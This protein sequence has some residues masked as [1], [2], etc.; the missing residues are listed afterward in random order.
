MP[1]HFLDAA[2]SGKTDWWRYGVGITLVMSGFIVMGTIALLVFSLPFVIT[3]ARQLSGDDINAKLTDFLLGNPSPVG[4]LANLLPH[5]CGLAT[6]ILVVSVIHQRSPL[7]LI[8]PDCQIRWGRVGWGF[9][10]WW[11]LM[12]GIDGINAAF[13]P[14]AFFLSL[15]QVNWAAWWSFVPVVFIFI[16]LQ[17]SAE[18]LFFRSYLIQGLGLLN[19]NPL[20]I[21]IVGG[22]MFALPHFFNPE[23]ERGA[24]WMGLTYFAMGVFGVLIT[25]RDNRL[26]LALGE[27]AAN[28]I[29]IALIS[30]SKDS[31]LKT[32]AILMHDDPDPQ[33][34]FW[35][36][37]AVMTLAY[38]LFFVWPKRQPTIKIKKEVGE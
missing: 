38:L 19:R 29:Y 18:E 28:N 4:L 8:S 12:M 31:A 6:L 30:N 25:V 26:E 14:E 23:M 5:V 24:I 1:H 21:Y 27:H 32:P 34:S 9:G 35:V 17:T 10:V 37:L 16:P 11:F 22:L 3:N 2:R 15:R 36:V 20:F 13:E 7:S 33:A